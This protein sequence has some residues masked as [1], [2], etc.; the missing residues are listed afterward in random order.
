MITPAYP[1][2][3]T[4]LLDARADLLD[5]TLYSTG[6]ALRSWHVIA[7][8]SGDLALIERGAGA[9][10][11]ITAPEILARTDPHTLADALVRLADRAAIAELVA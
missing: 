1:D 9:D 8:P 7:R 4:A 2:P 5:R 6:N 10:R 3:I 11:V